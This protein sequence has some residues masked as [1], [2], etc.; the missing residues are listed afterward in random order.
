[1]DTE[2]HFLLI[3]NDYHTTWVGLFCGF[4]CVEKTE[5]DNKKISAE[6]F[7]TIQT[8]L[9]KNNLSLKAISFCAANQGPGPFTTIR[10][11]IASLNGLSYVTNLPIVGVNCIKTLAHEHADLSSDSSYEYTIALANAFCNDVYYGII[12]TKNKSYS[13]GCMSFESILAHIQSLHTYSLR[14]VG[15]I[16]E[17]QKNKL[18]I[19]APAD[20]GIKRSYFENKNSHAASLEAMGKQAYIQWLAQENVTDQLL[21]LYF[22]SAAPIMNSRK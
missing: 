8:L 3:H 20:I 10:V 6:L 14:I 22:K 16:S 1:M 17:E 5:C 11:I 18:M 19:C 12:D 2:K 7:L 9:Q 15:L 4:F 13:E 21:P